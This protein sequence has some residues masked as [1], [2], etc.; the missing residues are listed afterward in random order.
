MQTTE[1][2]STLAKIGKVA[3]EALASIGITLNKESTE[4]SKEP[5]VTEL[6]MEGKLADGKTVM[7]EDEAKSAGSAVFVLTPDGD[8]IPLPMGEYEMQDG[9]KFMVAEEGKLGGMAAEEPGEEAPAEMEGDEMV[10]GEAP[11]MEMEDAPMMDEMAPPT[12]LQEAIGAMSTE[13]I[14]K[15]VDDMVMARLQELGIAPA[16]E[17][18]DAGGYDTAYPMEMSKEE[19]KAEEEDSTRGG[20][21]ELS[22]EE[23]TEEEVTEFKHSPS[24]SKNTNNKQEDR[25]RPSRADVGLKSSIYDLLS[26]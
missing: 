24:K 3:N 6:M 10:E 13:A 19:P 23:E 4:L 1:N 26:E 25:W 8:K 5:D 11:P 9:S 16:T 15:M 7:F 18:E 14:N 17:M 21:T 22:K 20:E 12:E 2:V